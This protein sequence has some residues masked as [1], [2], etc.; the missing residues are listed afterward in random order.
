MSKTLSLVKARNQLNRMPRT[1]ARARKRVMG[2]TRGT[3]QL[4]KKNPG[5]AVFGALVAGFIVS[6]MSRFV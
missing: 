3:V 2:W 5:R 4:A 6:K 1:L